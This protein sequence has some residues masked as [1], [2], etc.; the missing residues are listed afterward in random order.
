MEQFKGLRV[1]RPEQLFQ[2][3]ERATLLLPAGAQQAG[4]NLLGAGSG[5]GAITAPDLAGHHQRAEGLFGSP[6]GRIATRMIQKGEQGGSLAVEMVGQPLVG[7]NPVRQLGSLQSGLETA[8]GD[9]QPVG[10][11][12]AALVAGAHGESLLEHAFDQAG[13]AGGGGRGHLNH[14]PAAAQQMCQAG[15]MLAWVNCS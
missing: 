6:V 5:R 11:D 4:E 9:R 1:R 7:G 13:E 10:V 2:H 8:A 14:L 12:L 3:G 15:L